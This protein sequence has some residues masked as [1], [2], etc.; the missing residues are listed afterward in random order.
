MGNITKRRSLVTDSAQLLKDNQPLTLHI[1]LYEAII[2]ED[3]TAIR[4]LLR[5]HPVDQPLIIPSNNNYYTR[6]LHQVPTFLLLLLEKKT[7]SKEYNLKFINSLSSSRPSQNKQLNSPALACPHSEQC[8]LR[9]CE[10][11]SP[12]SLTSTPH[13]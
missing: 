1:K 6:P 9:F 12:Q 11:Q 5:N 13:T 3:C 4:T 7:L 10:S 8:T 2:K